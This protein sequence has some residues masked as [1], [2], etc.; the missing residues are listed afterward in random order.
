MKNVIDNNGNEIQVEDNVV[1]N[2]INGIHY[3][4]TS[5]EQ[6]EYD[7]KNIAWELDNIQRANDLADI[8]RRNAYI[9]ESDSLF[10][11]YQRN[12]ITKQEWLDKVQEIQI[13]FPKVQ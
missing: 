4:L 11:K 1:V 2:T 9:I 5:E 3:L 10:F 6:I 12:E 13:R 8:N 7:A